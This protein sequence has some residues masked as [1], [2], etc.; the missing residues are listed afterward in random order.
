MTT[1]LTIRIMGHMTAHIMGLTMDRI[2]DLTM[3]RTT[4]PHTI[5]IIALLGTSID[6]RVT[7]GATAGASMV[8]APAA[9]TQT[10]LCL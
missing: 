7:V 6:T 9:A 3:D 8:P 4:D 5:R 1:V 2:T 10:R